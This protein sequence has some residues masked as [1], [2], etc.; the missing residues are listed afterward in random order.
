V[1]AQLP[2]QVSPRVQGLFDE[3]QREAAAKAP[4]EPA[5]PV[6]L[7]PAPKD[8]LKGS[9]GIPIAPVISLGVAVAAGGIGLGLVVSASSLLSASRTADPATRDRLRADASTQSTIGYIAFAVAGAAALT[10]L[11]TFLVLD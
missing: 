11:I 6:Q 7:V 3:V 2:L 5:R 10:A 4:P 9:S 8:E 1:K